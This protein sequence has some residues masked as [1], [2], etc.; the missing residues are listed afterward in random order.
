M[1]YLKYA[2]YSYVAPIAIIVLCFV[3]SITFGFSDFTLFVLGFISFFPCG[4]AGLI[5]TILGIVYWN[6]RRHNQKVDV[7][8]AL[9]YLGIVMTGV[10]LSFMGLTYMMVY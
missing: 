4:I 8:I 5:F 1:H 7:G 3:D 2:Q 9:I 6:K 10:G